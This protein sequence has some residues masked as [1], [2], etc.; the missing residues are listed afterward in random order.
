MLQRRI[1]W[2]FLLVLGVGIAVSVRIVT[3]GDSV[4]AVNR[5]F[6]AEKLPLSQRIGELRGVIADEE[7]LLYEYYS[8]TATR[9]A[10]LAQRAENHARLDNVVEQLEKDIGSRE[11]V[12]GLRAQL[13]ELDQLSDAL[14]ATLSSK[15]VNW[16][17]ARAIL[18]Q[19]K[20]KV[21]QIEGSL[22]GMSSANRQA[23]DSLGT[24]SQNSVATMVGWVF[25][26]SVLIV[27]VALGVA[28]VLL[29]LVC[30]MSLC[31]MLVTDAIVWS[32][33]I[34]SSDISEGYEYFK[35]S[36]WWLNLLINLSVVTLPVVLL[37]KRS[38]ETSSLRF[39]RITMRDIRAPAIFCLV[40]LPVL[41]P[42]LIPIWGTLFVLAAIILAIVVVTWLGIFLRRVM[43]L[44][45]SDELLTCIFGGAF[46]ATVGFV[47][48][49]AFI[50]AAAGGL[51][52]FIEQEL[53]LPRLTSP[54]RK[55]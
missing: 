55:R 51:L 10:F 9:D 25:G 40:T 31:T 54:V 11:Q 38:L 6:I 36:P 24:N 52:A 2:V 33:V 15:V 12:A 50:G 8:Y 29:V 17:V 22:A 19:V 32:D 23:V 34:H 13:T 49:D 53:V 47:C 28:A 27:I 7:R 18:A 43:I 1:W 45:H 48:G 46:G 5:M 14:F 16:D 21:R 20:P 42:L 26:F 37:A 4:Q 41:Q 35:G 39:G 30:A 44:I 3:L